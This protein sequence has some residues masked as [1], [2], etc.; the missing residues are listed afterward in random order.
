MHLNKTLS[1]GQTAALFGVA[2][3]SIRRWCTSGKLIVT[4]RTFGGHRRFSL[5]Y[6][7]EILG[8]KVPNK[9]VGY[10][11]VSSHDQKKDLITQANVLKEAGCHQVIT[12][13]GSG[14]NCK[15]PGLTKLLKQIISGKL[16]GLMITHHDRLLRFGHEL[17]FKLCQWFSIDVI[18]LHE[19]ADK[20]FE[21]ELTE[22]VITLMTVFSARLYGKRSHQ[23]RQRRKA[24]ANKEL[25]A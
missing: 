4:R 10:A 20:S 19:K 2:V 21:M 3:V 1:I 13:L 9:V 16:T 11:R 8:E 22:D 15:K 18:V 23:N 5:S 12:D 14:M 7:L 6:L 24:E 25:I 17:I